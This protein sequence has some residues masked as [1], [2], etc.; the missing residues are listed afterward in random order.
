M[1]NACLSAL[2][3]TARLATQGRLRQINKRAIGESSA[4]P[5]Q[6]Y[7]AANN[8]VVSGFGNDGSGEPIAS[9]STQNRFGL[10][11]LLGAKPTTQWHGYAPTAQFAHWGVLKP[12]GR[13]I[14]C[15][16]PRICLPLR[17]GVRKCARLDAS[18]RH[19][20]YFQNPCMAASAYLIL[21]AIYWRLNGR[22]LIIFCQLMGFVYPKY[23]IRS[24]VA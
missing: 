15:G 4:T 9:P 23:I 7:F 20:L 18:P 5:T 24:N 21:I 16:A 6:T 22:R 11:S 17:S 10:A 3:R 2:G 19:A 12:L 13:F 1:P 14:A 8:G